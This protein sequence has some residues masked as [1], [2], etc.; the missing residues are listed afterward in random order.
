MPSSPRGVPA[1][2]RRGAGGTAVGIGL[3]GLGAAVLGHVA[4]A[5]VVI[6]VLLGVAAALG[7]LL[8]LVAS[9]RGLP[10]GVASAG[11]TGGTLL[12]VVGIVLLRHPLLALG[13]VTL[14]A[15]AAF[16]VA[17][18]AR[19]AAASGAGRAR[20]LVLVPG[21]VTLGAGLLLLIEVP[22]S[23]REFIGVVLGVQLIVDAGALL[24]A[25]HRG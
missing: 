4:L 21:A 8:L 22:G 19:L 2:R 9:L 15:G 3:G 7:G 1:V 25:Q 17:G 12:L 11:V 23:S 10:G 6:L 20:A 5:E 13:T 24:A 14:V 18:A 16:L